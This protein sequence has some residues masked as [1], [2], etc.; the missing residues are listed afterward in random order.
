MKRGYQSKCQCGGNL[1]VGL[2]EMRCDKC[3]SPAIAA[4][5]VPKKTRKQL[6]RELEE[7][8]VSLSQYRDW[9]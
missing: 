8:Q 1:Y 2:I 6:E 4:S 9:P 3:K 5:S 7:A